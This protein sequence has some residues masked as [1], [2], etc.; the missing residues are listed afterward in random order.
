L[1]ALGRSLKLSQQEPNKPIEIDVA[2]KNIPQRGDGATRYPDT[3]LRE[4]DIYAFATSLGVKVERTIMYED[5]F[6]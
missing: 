6:I 1:P 5:S 3:W 4:S 2:V